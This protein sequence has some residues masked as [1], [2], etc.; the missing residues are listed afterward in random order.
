VP[1]SIR[2]RREDIRADAEPRFDL[3]GLRAHRTAGNPPL[4]RV[5]A[6]GRTAQP[7]MYERAARPSRRGGLVVLAAKYKRLQPGI[8]QE[9]VHHGDRVRVPS[10]I[11]PEQHEQSQSRRHR[12]HRG[13][14]AHPILIPRHQSWPGRMQLRRKVRRG[15]PAETGRGG[16]QCEPGGDGQHRI[17]SG[18][19]ARC[20]RSWLDDH[21][22]G[23]ASPP[24]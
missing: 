4:S 5:P 7:G 18:V 19:A 21:V 22:V 13:R 14:S 12:T 10:P 20:C 9:C 23:A 17:R 2:S 24:V 3:H 15:T 1:G 11:R 16:C 6:Y 8:P